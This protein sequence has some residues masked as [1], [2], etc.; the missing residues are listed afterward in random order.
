MKKIY[1]LSLLLLFL[2]TACETT[3]VIP[4]APGPPGPQGPQGPRGIDGEEAYVIEYIVDFEAPDYSVVLPF[5]DDFQ[6]LSSDVVLV[7]LLWEVQN[8]DGEEVEIWRALPQSQLMEFGWLQ[9]NYDFTLY[10]V[11]LFMETDFPPEQLGPIYTDE[12][13]ARVVVVPGQFLSN[14]RNNINFND[15]QTVKEIFGLP[16][17][18]LPKDYVIPERI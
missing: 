10:D 14:G 5:P 3:E 1:T 17:I 12:W 11:S 16:K 18:E 15:Y 13:V 2:G 6:A 9:Y 4:G 8:I 7:Y